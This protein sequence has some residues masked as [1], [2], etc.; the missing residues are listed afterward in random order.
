MR[1]LYQRLL[2]QGFNGDGRSDRASLQIV[3]RL[4]VRQAKCTQGLQSDIL[5]TNDPRIDRDVEGYEYLRWVVIMVVILLV[6]Y[7]RLTWLRNL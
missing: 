4:A 7:I 3:T 5:C 2:R 6:D 1:P